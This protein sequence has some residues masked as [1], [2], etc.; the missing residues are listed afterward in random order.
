MATTRSTASPPPEP[1][2]SAASCAYS[3]LKAPPPTS[4]TTPMT[5]LL[6]PM[7]PMRPT[8]PT[9][10]S[11]T[12]LGQRIR[13][14]DST[15]TTYYVW[16]SLHITHEH[17]GSGNVTRRYTHGYTPIEGVSSLID[18]EDAQSSHYLYHFDQCECSRRYLRSKLQQRGLSRLLS[19]NCCPFDC[20]ALPKVFRGAKS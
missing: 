7:S 10:S 5:I 4:P 15:G 18:V 12:A 3:S 20:E 17:D 2:H 13:K 19:E 6:R 14:T 9:T 1:T 16:D 11:K 8:S